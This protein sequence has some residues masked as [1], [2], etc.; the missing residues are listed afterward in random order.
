M[1]IQDKK[2]T[3][4]ITGASSGI[5]AVYAERLA[6]RGYDLILVARDQE[7]L[8]ALASKLTQATP[9]KVTLLPADLTKTADLRRVEE[10]L[11]TDNDIT[12]LVNNA[13]VG[14]TATLVDSNPDSL[15][16]MIQLNVIALTRLARAIAPKLVQRGTGIIINISS[17]V[18]LAPEMLNGV[19]SG[20]KAYV[21]NLT[22]SMNHE[23]SDK[24]V[25]VQAVLPGATSTDFWSLS[26]VPV[27]HLPK[28][29][30]MTAEDMVDAS[31]AG[32]DR[33]ELVTIPSLPDVDHWNAFQAARLVLQPN[34]SHSKPAARYTSKA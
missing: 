34:L 16:A 1:T 29:I 28:Q 6:R 9:R 27:E 7:K 12:L 31:L 17:I 20:T 19:Y 13:G 18:A 26:G 23:L 21:L 2:G 30:V 8:Q 15:D 10:R 11:A 22:Q 24:G 5:G 25:Q 14:A 33:N 4:L 32:L 3:A